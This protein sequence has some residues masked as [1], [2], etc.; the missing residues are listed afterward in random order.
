MAPNGV[1]VR[2]Q[3]ADSSFDAGEKGPRRPG[4][5]E[6]GDSGWVGRADISGHALASD[7][8]VGTIADTPPRLAESLTEA[9]DGQRLIKDW[10][11]DN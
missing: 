4:I 11:A 3:G 5:I 9:C 10:L 8:K 2:L 7:M 1:V 6:G